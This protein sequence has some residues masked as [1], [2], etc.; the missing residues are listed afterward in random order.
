MLNQEKALTDLQQGTF[1]TEGDSIDRT[2]WD[3]EILAAAGLNVRLFQNPL[4]AGGKLLDQT[5]STQAGLIPNGRKME[6]R[7]L[8]VFYVSETTGG[9]KATAADL[10][11]FYTQLARTTVS[12]MIANREFGQWTVQELLGV[13]LLVALNPAV[14]LN[15]PFLLPEFRG[16]F[17]LNRKI[18]LAGLTPFYL[19]VNHS[20]APTA[21]TIGDRL[22]IGLAGIETRLN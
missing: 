18:T 20:I 10:Q 12:F 14:T 5:N 13:P 1:G 17:P 3:E 4:G 21:S 2:L 11:A 15:L 8:K 9:V 22:R 7:A 16:I 19:E 6:V